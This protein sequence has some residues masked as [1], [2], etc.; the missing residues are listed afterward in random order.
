MQTGGFEEKQAAYAG[1]DPQALVGTYHRIGHY[2]PAYE[3]LKI[4][5]DVNALVVLLETGEEVAYPI[6]DIRT[7]PHPDDETPELS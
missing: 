1:D 3:V 5:D 7:D 6:A 4:V 2:G